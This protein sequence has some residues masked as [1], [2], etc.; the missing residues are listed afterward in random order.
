MDAKSFTALDREIVTLAAV[1]DLI[2]SMVNYALFMKGHRLENP[3]LMFHTGEASKLFLIIL[4]DFLSLPRDGTFG[5]VRPQVDGS[6][7]RTYL[8]HL[9]RVAADPKL[10]GDTELLSSSVKGFAEWLDGMAVVEKVWLPSIDR[11]GTLCVQR[12]AYLKICGTIS[13]HGFTRLGDVV[14]KVQAILAENGTNIDEGQSYLVIPEF[15]EWFQD[16]IFIA[17]S[18]LIA[19]HLNEIRWAIYLYLVAEFDRA[20]TPTKLV[21][22]LQMYEF[23]VPATI[24]NPLVRSMYWDLMNGVR[25]PPYFPRFTVDRY[26]R[27]L[28]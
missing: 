13:K 4:A 5:L 28:Y 17:S 12:M 8:G 18:T 22:G 16:N 3:T 7:G 10:P 25:S 20:Y 24:T 2:G 26:I 6:L 11:D 23:D 15:Q 27:E 9:R 1:W 19:W 14:N 21:Q